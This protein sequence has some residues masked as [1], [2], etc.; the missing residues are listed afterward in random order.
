MLTLYLISTDPDR[1]LGIFFP[2]S[3][4]KQERFAPRDRHSGKIDASIS[5]RQCT[6]SQEWLE[7]PIS[8]VMFPWELISVDKKNSSDYTGMQL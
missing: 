4:Q 8:V 5:I 2:I 6:S 1:S 7:N 3:E